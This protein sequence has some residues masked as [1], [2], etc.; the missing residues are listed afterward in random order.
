MEHRDKPVAA[1]TCAMEK[2]VQD[3]GNMEVETIRM[4]VS[5]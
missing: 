2:R 4:I 5:Y 1:L 3:F